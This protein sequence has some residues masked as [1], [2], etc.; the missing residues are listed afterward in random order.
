LTGSCGGPTKHEGP[1]LRSRCGADRSVRP[2]DYR[3]S[4]RFQRS[5][6]PQ[7]APRGA[8]LQAG[9]RPSRM[10]RCA[11]PLDLVAERGQLG[12][13][14]RADVSHEDRRTPIEAEPAARCGGRVV[15]GGKDPICGPVETRTDRL[16]L[17]W[18]SVQDRKPLRE[19]GPS[20]DGGA[21]D[22]ARCE[23]R[24]PTGR[25]VRPIARSE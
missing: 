6:G 2:C 25:P 4:S 1:T 23:R 21:A 5:C 8:L 11:P 16:H 19:R 14:H 18:W 10:L 15:V 17:L 13:R 22:D 20:R 12:T 3:V 24:R 9:V 7:R